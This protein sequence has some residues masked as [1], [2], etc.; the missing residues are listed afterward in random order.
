MNEP[1]VTQS[2]SMLHPFI[3]T[4]HSHFTHIS[5]TFHSRFTHISLTLH[6]HYTHSHYTHSRNGQHNYS[7]HHSDRCLPPLRIC[8]FVV[9]AVGGCSSKSVPSVN[10][11]I[12][13]S[14]PWVLSLA[15]SVGLA[16]ALVL[17][18]APA[19]ALALG[20]LITLASLLCAELL[21][22]SDCNWSFPTS[23]ILF[24]KVVFRL[25][26]RIIV[27]LTANEAA[28]ILLFFWNVL[29]A[30]MFLVKSLKTH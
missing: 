17:A 23:I 5:L 4:L 18:P 24:F 10:I 13:A 28:F 29:M 22:L 1:A 2:V 3:L 27:A 11:D 30:A 21:V 25:V 6:S 26:F 19:P 12:T 20:S 14:P 16:P 7:S 8:E 15:L 9:L